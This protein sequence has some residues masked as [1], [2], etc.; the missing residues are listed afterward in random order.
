MELQKVMLSLGEEVLKDMILELLEKYIEERVRA[1]KS[2]ESILYFTV[3]NP[4]GLSSSINEFLEDLSRSVDRKIEVK[5]GPWN[6]RL[7]VGK[8]Q[9][10]VET[11]VTRLRDILF[12]DAIY[13]ELLSALESEEE[14]LRV[15]EDEDLPRELGLN[16]PQ[17]L[18]KISDITIIIYPYGRPRAED[19]YRFVQIVYDRVARVLGVDRAVVKVKAYGLS[20]SRELSSIEKK[21]RELKIRVYR[22][23]G[24]G[25]VENLTVILTTPIEIL[26]DK[27]YKAIY[28][29]SLLGNLV[30]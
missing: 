11:H 15:D 23:S 1:T 25:D 24:D 29:G 22:S 26:S 16:N 5:E 30:R 21:L 3:F 18:E 14:E 10:I 12:Y 2:I 9:F 13:Q 6:T 20:K 27:V 7:L 28:G 4:K 17:I 19:V 8:S